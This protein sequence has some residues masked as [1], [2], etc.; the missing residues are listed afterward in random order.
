VRRLLIEGLCQ[1]GDVKI[2]KVTIV[3]RLKVFLE[4]DLEGLFP[5]E[6]GGGGGGWT[7]VIAHPQRNDGNADDDLVH[8]VRRMRDVVLADNKIGADNDNNHNRTVRNIVLAVGPEGGWEEPY[9]LD[10]FRRFDF[11]QITLG[12]RILRTD[13]AVV[14]LLSLAHDSLAAA[15]GD[16]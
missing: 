7:R 4:D 16:D 6:G 12:P 8:E 3:K 5:M 10:M 11:Q 9:E 14:S 13:V 1:A 15:M 2:P